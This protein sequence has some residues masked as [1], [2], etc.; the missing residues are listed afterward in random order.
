MDNVF[1]LTII[2]PECEFFMGDVVLLN[3][4]TTEGRM[5]ILPHHSALIAGLVPTI[6]RFEEA[7]GKNHEAKT[8]GGI[9]KVRKN[10]VSIL[11][12]T[13]EWVE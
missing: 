6:T 8:S 13:A 3:C 2:T 11:C 5:G 10:K 7:D 4:E 12:D 9:L 1:N